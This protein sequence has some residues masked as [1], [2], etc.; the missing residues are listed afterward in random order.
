MFDADRQ[1]DSDN[2]EA[3]AELDLVR[4]AQI[5]R[6]Q[7]AAFDPLGLVAV[8]DQIAAHR[9]RDAGE[10]HVVDRGAE[11][12]ADRLDLRQPQRLAPGDALGAL[13]LALEARSALSLGMKSG[14]PSSPATP[15]PARR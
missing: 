1:F 12:A 7:R 10:Q 6:H 11:R 13:R 9:A 5:D 2:A 3:V 15:A 8:V 14:S 4:L